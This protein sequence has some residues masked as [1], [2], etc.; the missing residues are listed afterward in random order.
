MADNKYAKKTELPAVQKEPVKPIVQASL[1]KK[2]VGM[3]V[4]EFLFSGDAREVRK[5]VID[6]TVKP[7]ILD[8]IYN[9]L[10]DFLWGLIYGEDVRPYKRSK[11][12][13]SRYEKTNYQA[14]YYKNTS[15]YEKTESSYRDEKLDLDC[16]EF[17]NPDKSPQENRFDA[18]A[19]KAGMVNRISMYE[20]GASVQDLYDFCRITCNDWTADRWGWTDPEEFEKGCIIQNVRGGA[21][22]SVPQPSPIGE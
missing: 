9:S 1:K 21:I 7:A 3:K 19:V 18:S 17:L 16:I 12:P 13:G 14:A 4:K 10:S 11:K 8:T 6:N 20:D 5:S 15:K 2:S 22:M